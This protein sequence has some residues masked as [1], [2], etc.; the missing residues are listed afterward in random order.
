[1]M[2]GLKAGQP[3]QREF[4]VLNNYEEDFEIESVTSQKGTIKLL[5]KTMTGNRCHLRVEMTPP[6]QGP[7][8]TVA[9]D[10]L[11]IKIKDNKTLTVPFRG[12]YQ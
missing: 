1:M 9:S 12:F 3:V 5:E 8:S 6:E 2:F 4:W 10:T 7:D 11:E